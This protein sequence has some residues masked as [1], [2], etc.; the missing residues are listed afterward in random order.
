MCDFFKLRGWSKNPLVLFAFAVSITVLM[1]S[2]A[3]CEYQASLICENRFIRAKRLRHGCV[4]A[5]QDDAWSNRRV[6]N[7]RFREVYLRH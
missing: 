7:V 2:M 4:I 3:L 5:R 6:Q 1:S